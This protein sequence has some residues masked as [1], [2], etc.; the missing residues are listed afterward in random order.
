MLAIDG[1]ARCHGLTRAVAVDGLK[2]ASLGR[3]Y[4]SGPKAGGGIRRF[5]PA[6]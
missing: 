3:L 5:D 4:L 1:L 6:S 2:Q